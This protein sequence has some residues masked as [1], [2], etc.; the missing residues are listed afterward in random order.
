MALRIANSTR[1]Q[2]RPVDG[3][4]AVPMFDWRQLRRYG[5]S[6]QELSAGLLCDN[7]ASYYNSFRR[8]VL[9][10]GNMH[11]GLAV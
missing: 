4:Q 3:V 11:S 6:E 5:I 9:S 10:D 2:D 7:V 8:D 1:P